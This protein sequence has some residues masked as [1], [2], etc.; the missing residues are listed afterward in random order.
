MQRSIIIA[1]LA[2]YS[3]F[4]IAQGQPPGGALDLCTVAANLSAY[5][6]REVRLTAFFAVGRE[7][8]ALYDPKCQDGKPMVWVE[9]KPKAA[10]E[11]LHHEMRHVEVAGAP[12][13]RP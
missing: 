4:C 5:S 11:E 8:V 2:G 1:L 7:N 10:V 13:K 9:F 6:G 3:D 12:E